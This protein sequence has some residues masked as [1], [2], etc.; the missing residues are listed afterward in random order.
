MT[1]R[2]F[3]PRP[4]QEPAIAHLLDVPRCALF[5]PM[6]GGKSSSVLS[7]L[8]TLYMSG[9]ES[10]PALVLAPLRVAKN[11]WPDECG[12]WDFP[13]ISCSAIVGTPEERIAA[14][15]RDASIYTINYENVPWLVEHLG[16]DW[17]FGTVVCDES[18][19]T[20]SLRISVQ[21]HPKTKKQF[22]RAT[23]GKRIKPLAKI[24][25]TKIHR[26]INLTGSPAANGLTGLW[27]QT[28]LLD[29]GSRLGRT[30][31]GFM[32]RWF[33]KGYDG[34]SVEPKDHA[35]R[36]IQ[37][38][39]RDIC[40]A[41]D[42]ADYLDIQKPIVQN[43]FVDLPAKARTLYRDMEKRMFMEIEGN[44]VEAFNAASRTIKCLQ[45]ANGAA[46]TDDSTGTDRP[47]AEVHDAK[48]Q[49]LESIIE[50]AAGNPVLVSYWFKPDLVRLKKAFPQGRELDAKKQTEDDWNAGKIPVLFAHPASAGHGLNLQDGG[51]II[52][53][54]AQWWDLELYE[55]IL[56][57]IGPVRQMQSGHNRPVFVYRIVARDTVDEDV[58]ERIETKA[59]VQDILK[60]AMKRRKQS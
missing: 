43:V 10:Q 42:L 23:S 17:P 48:L 6:G 38:K 21:Q 56:E 2:P 25:H 39:L 55:Q 46:Y 8:D 11:T 58:I 26:W 36:E 54:F 47:W 30:Y 13:H 49:A 40:L 7:A 32:Q 27:G 37:D 50:E 1:A 51:N 15:K 14:L 34:F 12:K 18:T 29:M 44:E 9:A 5:L 59:E 60:R 16:G 45:L 52:V 24:A 28:W 3:T 22:L 41:I 33:Q 20:K 53:Y 31:E 57:R 35:Q 4:W 19:R